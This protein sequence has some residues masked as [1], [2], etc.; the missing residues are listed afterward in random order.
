M[1]L[2]ILQEKEEPEEPRECV[3]DDLPQQDTEEEQ[4]DIIVKTSNSIKNIVPSIVP[5]CC[6]KE[7]AEVRSTALK[8]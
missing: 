8:R 4:C 6:L 1:K 7:T 5:D 3:M 2:I